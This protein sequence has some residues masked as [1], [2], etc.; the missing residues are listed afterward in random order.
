MF[1]RITRSAIRMETVRQ[2]KRSI[3]WRSLLL[4]AVVAFPVALL[5]MGRSPLVAGPAIVSDRSVMVPIHVEFVWRSVEWDTVQVFQIT[6]APTEHQVTARRHAAA[7]RVHT[8]LRVIAFALSLMAFV[9][10]RKQLPVIQT[11][12]LPMRRGLVLA[13]GAAG[14]EPSE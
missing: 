14:V 8:F 4:L 7:R 6:S 12:R 5:Q 3:N 1:T 9:V 11:V 2:W 13:V 10:F